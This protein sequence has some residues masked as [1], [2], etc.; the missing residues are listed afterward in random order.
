[1]Q[2]L[3]KI[4]KTRR[5][6]RSRARELYKTGVPTPF[7]VAFEIF[8][9]D[10]DFVEKN[11]HEKLADFRVNNNREFF[12]YPIDKAI[13]LL[14]ESDK[15]TEENLYSAMDITANL[16][17]KYSSWIKT[18]IVSIRIVQPRERVWLEI[19]QEEEIAGYLV[20]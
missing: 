20:D 1:M 4:G 8:C 19:T 16:Q 10:Y 3:I 13:S 5:D 2:G 18:D 7:Q 14:Q 6:S 9:D 15:T 12:N 11:I 17:T